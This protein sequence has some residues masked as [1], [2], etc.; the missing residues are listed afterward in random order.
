VRT[1]TRLNA[2]WGLAL[3]AQAALLLFLSNR[4]SASQF[5]AI[6]TVLGFGVP[7]LLGAATFAYVRRRRSATPA[8]R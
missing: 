8:T 3:V 5:G 2:I 4:V 7:A 6:S 1:L